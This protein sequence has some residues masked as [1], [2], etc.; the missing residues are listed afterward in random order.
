MTENK[1]GPTERN[2]TIVCTLDVPTRAG[3]GENLD[4]NVYL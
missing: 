4:A 2:R 1:R 3:Q